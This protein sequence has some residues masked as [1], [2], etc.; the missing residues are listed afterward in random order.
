MG[1]TRCV[2]NRVYWAK[3]RGLH[4]H[5]WV[6]AALYV[7]GY[8]IGRS[9]V[10]GEWTGVMEERRKSGGSCCSIRVGYTIVRPIGG[11]GWVMG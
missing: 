3:E 11:I 9:V 8:A 1:T 4:I 6:S 2:G 7:R 5:G 10:G